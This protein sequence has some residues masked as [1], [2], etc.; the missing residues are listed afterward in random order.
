MDKA[1]FKVILF[2]GQMKVEAEGILVISLNQQSDKNI[3]FPCWN[4]ICKSGE[5]YIT[6]SLCKNFSNIWIKVVWFD[7]KNVVSSI[8][9]NAE[10]SYYWHAGFAGP[11]G[12]ESTR[13]AHHQQRHAHRPQ[14]YA[15]GVRS[16]RP[17][18]REPASFADRRT[19]AHADPAAADA[20]HACTRYQIQFARKSKKC[21][22]EEEL[23]I[24]CEQYNVLCSFL[25]LKAA[26]IL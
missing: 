8:C 7:S 20:L 16:T 5:L 4:K 9:S 18:V 6:K 21:F 3:F 1:R 10:L 12:H 23:N 15:A 24:Y 22:F 2:S 26:V 13:C 25:T 19:A 17:P 11:C 14:L